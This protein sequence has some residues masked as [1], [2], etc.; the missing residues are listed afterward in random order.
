MQETRY[1]INYFKHHEIIELKIFR[2]ISFLR[3]LYIYNKGIIKL[4]N[5]KRPLYRI[6]RLILVELRVI[7]LGVDGNITIYIKK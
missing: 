2:E 5:I 7:R 4:L 3:E 1:D 6:F